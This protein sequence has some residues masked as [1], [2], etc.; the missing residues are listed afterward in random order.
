M[1]GKGGGGKKRSPCT[2]NP[3]PALVR[4]KRGGK[5]EIGAFS[6]L[7]PLINT[8]QQIFLR[9][10]PEKK[11]GD[12]RKGGGGLRLNLRI[13]LLFEVELEMPKKRECQAKGGREGKKKGGKKKHLCMKISTINH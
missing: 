13:N 8:P 2:I 5:L 6:F 9:K 4:K 1:W 7:L 12:K 11:K 10:K 3:C